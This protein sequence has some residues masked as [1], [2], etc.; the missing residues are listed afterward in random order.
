M[1]IG[2]SSSFID[3][4]LGL[5]NPNS[6]GGTSPWGYLDVTNGIRSVSGFWPATGGSGTTYSSEICGDGVS[7]VVAI[8]NLTNAQSFR[9]YRITNS[10]NNNGS[11][12]FSSTNFERIEL[13]W[14]GTEAVIGTASGGTGSARGLILRTNGIN[15]IS[16]A[17]SGDITI[18]DGLPINFGTTSGTQLGV[19]GGQKIGFWGSTPIIRPAA[20]TPPSGGATVDSECRASLSDLVT[21]LQAIGLI[22]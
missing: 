16:I 6:G 9:V 7:N 19:S 14:S 11:G 21:K 17:A 22:S 18:A 3:V 12:P 10:Q 8:R 20:V 2:N 13:T 4:R 1:I 5:G 15:R